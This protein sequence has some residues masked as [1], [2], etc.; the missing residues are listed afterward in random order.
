M[1]ERLEE[2]TGLKRNQARYAA[3][4][5]SW[6]KRLLREHNVA[7]ASERGVGVRILTEPERVDYALWHLMLN[8]RAVM[9]NHR[10]AL[11]T[12]A[13]KLEEAA[14]VRNEQVLS[15]SAAMVSSAQIA[16]RG[17]VDALQPQ[18]QLPRL[19]EFKK[20]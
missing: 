15:A 20:G 14:R 12:D 5:T 18:Q 4:M 6:K 19:R 16:Q 9:R 13:T 3:V 10:F 2:I 1:H 8:A 17:L 11:M 7:A